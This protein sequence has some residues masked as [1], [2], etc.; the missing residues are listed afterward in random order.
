VNAALLIDGAWLGAPT[1]MPITNPWNGE[2][3]ARV[4]CATYADLQHALAAARRGRTRMAAL[5]TGERAAIL[6]RAA[7]ALREHH[8]EMA[9]LLSR[10]SGKPI[11]GARREVARCIHTLELSA[12]EAT[13]LAGETIAFDSFE[14]GGVRS[15]WYHHEPLGIVVAITP[16]NDPLNLVAH[17][18][19][20]ALA[21]GNAVILKPSAQAPLAALRLARMLVDAGLPDGA[22]AVLTGRGAE[23]GDALVANPDVAV[24]SFTG[25]DATGARIAAAAGAKKLLMELGSNSPVIVMPSADVA[26]AAVATVAGAFSAAGQNCIG[27][28]RV[29]VERGVYAAFRDAV[30]AATG[31]LRVGDPSDEYTEV[32]PLIN[33]R[34]ACRVEAWMQEAIAA[35]ARLLC[36][37]ARRGALLEPVVLE[38]VP[39]HCS[40]VCREVFGPVLSLFPVDTLDEAI[41]RAN[42]AESIIHAAIFTRDIDEA[43]CASHELRAGGVMINDSTDYRLDAMPFGAAGRGGLGRE[44][45][46]FA[47]RE[48]TQTKVVCITRF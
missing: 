25:G 4:P 21:G 12:E 6:R 15:G 24:V 41:E 48:M 37:G 23:L 17:K 34:E 16:F 22:L 39:P 43:M 35:G 3:I 13:R 31:R 7:A 33:E 38:D 40:I 9:R 36:G 27:V 14:G 30:V 2:E 45:V 26:R 10:E 46:R 18:L 11:R 44:G 47:L 19:G 8:E 29:F 28:Q 32:G 5:S 42:A 1:D 20:P